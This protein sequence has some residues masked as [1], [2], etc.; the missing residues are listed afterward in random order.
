MNIPNIK[1]CRQMLRRN[2]AVLFSYVRK[3]VVIYL[4][5]ASGLPFSKS[6][7]HAGRPP[8]VSSASR[9]SS[10]YPTD[11]LMRPLYIIR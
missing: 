7:L 10:C 11:T 8:G 4:R 3:E 1:H 5:K 2:V 9:E 6:T